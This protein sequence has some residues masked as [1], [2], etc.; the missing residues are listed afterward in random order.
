MPG[1]FL[2]PYKSMP[3]S[4]LTATYGNADA[5]NVT[6]E[7]GNTADEQEEEL[8]QDVWTLLQPLPPG[9]HWDQGFTQGLHPSTD[10][11]DDPPDG[12]QSLSDVFGDYPEEYH[13]SQH[14]E[15]NEA[16]EKGESSLPQPEEDFDTE[17]I[18]ADQGQSPNAEVPLPAG[19][20]PQLTPQQRARLHALLRQRDADGKVP[21]PYDL[22]KY[23]GDAAAWARLQ[24]SHEGQLPCLPQ[25][26]QSR[27]DM[28]ERRC[29]G[30]GSPS[31]STPS[32]KQRTFAATTEAATSGPREVTS[33]QGER[34][35]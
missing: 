16:C 29:Q 7:Q 1:D 22:G 12:M 9:W 6:D 25:K 15:N 34:R 24:E 11:F 14:A 2:A 5:A 19:T 13:N 27:G 21:G 18:H 8:P 3:E 33:E 4:H 23:A 26:K 10:V 31:T 28:G 20:P 17:E 30:M 32:S 35:R